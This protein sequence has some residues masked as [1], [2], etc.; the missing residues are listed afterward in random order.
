MN[1][2]I[3]QYF[4]VIELPNFMFTSAYSKTEMLETLDLKCL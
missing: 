2:V 4:I 3:E 1:I